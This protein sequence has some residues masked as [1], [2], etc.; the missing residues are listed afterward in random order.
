VLENLVA[1][2][3]Q[4][5]CDWTE[6]T[7]GRK[8]RRCYFRDRDGREVDF[9]LVEGSRVHVVAEV[10]QPEETLHKPLAFFAHKLGNPRVFQLAKEMER[11]LQR[12]NVEILPLA[13]D[14]SA[15]WTLFASNSSAPPDSTKYWQT[16]MEPIPTLR[17]GLL[18]FSPSILPID[19]G[20]GSVDELFGCLG[21]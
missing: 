11:P 2:A 3:L 10:K 9:L 1:C 7:I 12:G 5:F 18:T 14:S 8:I 4:K 20:A 6:D 13:G 16:S 21:L 19:N 15:P 17:S